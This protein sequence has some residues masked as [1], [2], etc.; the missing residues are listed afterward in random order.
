LPGTGLSLCRCR[1]RNRSDSNDLSAAWTAST[2]HPE[3]CFGCRALSLLSDACQR[4]GKPRDGLSLGP[5]Q[6]PRPRVVEISGPSVDLCIAGDAVEA[7]GPHERDWYFRAA[8]PH[9]ARGA[10]ERF[11]G[12]IGCGHAASMHNFYEPLAGRGRYPP[13]CLDPRRPRQNRAQATAR[14]VPPI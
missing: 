11:E 9:T 2:S 4:P 8:V 7:S 10:D 6:R 13:S 5:I 1:P 12:S 14:P 3:C